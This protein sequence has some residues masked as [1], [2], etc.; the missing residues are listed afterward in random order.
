MVEAFIES[1]V[2]ANFVDIVNNNFNLLVVFEH[3][4]N[5]NRIG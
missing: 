4:R 3:G 1:W 5:P 2:V